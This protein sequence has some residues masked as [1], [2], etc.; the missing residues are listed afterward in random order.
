MKSENKARCRPFR[1]LARRIRGHRGGCLCTATREMR[2]REGE[3]V[4]L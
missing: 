1:D 2:E 3:R 4:E